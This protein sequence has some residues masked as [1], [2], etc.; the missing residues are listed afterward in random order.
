MK[1]LFQPY[2]SKSDI[3]ELMGGVRWSS[4]CVVFQECKKLE[5]DPF[6]LRPTKVP[7]HLVFKMLG[8]DYDF[9]LQ[10]YRQAKHMVSARGV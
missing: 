10:Q 1:I 4:A 5:N 6:D 7:S 9:T 2:A 8:I 3:Q